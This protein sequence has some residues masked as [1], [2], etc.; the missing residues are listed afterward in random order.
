[1]ETLFLDLTIRAALL[2]VA[3]AAILLL[4]RVKDAAA[5]H[6]VWS[7][8][9]LAMLLLPIWTSWGP[10]ATLRILPQSSEGAPVSTSAAV[11]RNFSE[12]SNS[13][14]NL[15]QNPSPAAPSWL[16]TWQTSLLTVYLL[17]ATALL[18]RLAIGALRARRLLNNANLRGGRLTS[19]AFAVPVTVGWSRPC[20]ILPEDWPT[21]APAKLEA[22]LA[23]EGAHAR[24]HDPLFQGL[25]LLNRAIFWF[26]PA[27]WWLARRIS[28]L[29]E[30]TCDDVVLSR[31]HSASEYSE[32]LMDM[33]RAVARAGRR[34]NVA[35]V[36]MPGTSLSHRIERMAESR[37]VVRLSRIRAMLVGVACAT[38]CTALAAVGVG[39]TQSG[40][41]V[42][43]PAQTARPTAPT[44]TENDAFSVR[45]NRNGNAPSPGENVVS[46]DVTVGLLLVSAYELPESQFVGLPS[47][48]DSEHF[49]VVS[50]SP[51]KPT[52]E[53]EKALTQS[54]LAES[55]KL[56][57]H[58][59]TRDLPYYELV[60]A[61][62]G[63]LGPKM[64][65]NVLQCDASAPMNTP[66]F[67][68]CGSISLR[69]TASTL[70]Y[71]VEGVTIRQFVSALAGF[72]SNEKLDRSGYNRNLDR[73]IVDYTGL[74]GKFDLTLEF[75]PEWPGFATLSGTAIPPSLAT[76]LED[77][78][79][80]KLLPRIGPVQ[81]M[82]VDRLELPPPNQAGQIGGV[83]DANQLPEVVES[84][85]FDG[86]RRISSDELASRI[87]ARPGDRF[88]D[89]M[90]EHDCTVLRN[91]G[92][93]DEASC[94]VQ[95]SANH[96]NGRI[97]VFHLRERPTI[98]A[99]SYEGFQ[100][101]SADDVRNRLLQKHLVLAVEQP[102]DRTLVISAEKALGELLAER[103]HPNATIRSSIRIIPGT[104][105]VQ[106]FVNAQ[107]EPARINR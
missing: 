16:W 41:G 23:H 29:A 99:I 64:R 54:L 61:A 30:E 103:G 14:M 73:P 79:G 5:Q 11:I 96:S 63:G 51:T 55:F 28:V 1:M 72:G 106:L 49:D 36:A 10:K 102:L 84:I 8:V 19:T 7:G 50:A 35:G 26:H 92:F 69:R 70:I 4:L 21:W 105:N 107:E 3:T 101:V 40:R 56:A 74:N 2:V 93:F 91:S 13:A 38:A 82:V 97:V 27:A 65:A 85:V 87:F 88:N 15:P 43:A 42:L 62:P 100:S 75:A 12:R 78:L 24:R 20:V 47:S 32:Y 80:L 39:R 37:A 22:V 31:G 46:K 33:A 98:R 25:A 48:I 60:R 17:G 90:M 89:K 34:I 9:V 77:Q 67:R 104:N 53:R 83:V 71:E 95:K 66:A 6:K 81:V 58:P 52:P 57:M 76:S 44:A 18:G 59:E 86:N 68:A 45:F 94:E